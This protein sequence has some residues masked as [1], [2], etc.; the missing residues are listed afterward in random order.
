VQPFKP[1][2]RGSLT[3]LFFVSAMHRTKLPEEKGVFSTL[4][5]IR[6][7]QFK[8][9]HFAANSQKLFKV[10]T[11][12]K[13]RGLHLFFTKAIMFLRSSL[14]SFLQAWYENNWSY[15]HIM[16]VGCRQFLKATKTSDA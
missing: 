15:Y 14:P 5:A 11:Y 2:V 8:W 12:S 13:K 6:F 3:L 1:S 16:K 9:S 7:Q 4:S 10:L